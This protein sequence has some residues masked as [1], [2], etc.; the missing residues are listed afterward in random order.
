MPA[1]RTSTSTQRRILPVRRRAALAT[2]AVVAVAVR[3]LRTVTVLPV[4][5]RG[6]VRNCWPRVL[7]CMS[8]EIRGQITFG[9]VVGTA[10]LT[11]AQQVATV[12]S[13]GVGAG[14]VVKKNATAV[15]VSL[16]VRGVTATAAHIHTGG[17]YCSNDLLLSVDV[18]STLCA[19]ALVCSRAAAG[20]AGGVLC[21]LPVASWPLV[22]FD[23]EIGASAVATVLSGGTYFNVHTA[24]NPGGAC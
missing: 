5:A 12:S 2:D 14:Y 4:V 9:D 8:G 18:Q 16:D 1:A 11:S 19:L 20:T 7:V 6:A 3:V 24:A 15:T 23:C 21:G 13:A 17:A 10:Y 22:G